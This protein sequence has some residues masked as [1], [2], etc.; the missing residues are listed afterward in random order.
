MGVPGFFIWLIKNSDKNNKFIINNL[1]KI[2]SRETT[3]IIEFKD[4]DKNTFE[5]F[6]TILTMLNLKTKRIRFRP[7]LKKI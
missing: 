6:V 5:L 1:D 3:I 4:G 7:K 2:L